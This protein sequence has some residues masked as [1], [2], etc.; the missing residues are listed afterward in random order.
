MRVD[1]RQIVRAWANGTAVQYWW[2]SDAIWHDFPVFEDRDAFDEGRYAIGH[3]DLDWRIK[4][5]EKKEVSLDDKQS[6]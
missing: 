5:N 2:D 1:R 3:P 4:P 6:K